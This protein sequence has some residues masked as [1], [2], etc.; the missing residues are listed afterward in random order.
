MD[1]RALILYQLALS[2]GSVQRCT[3]DITDAEA[4]TRP[5]TKLAPVVW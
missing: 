2:H 3:G 1:D 4:G 5:N